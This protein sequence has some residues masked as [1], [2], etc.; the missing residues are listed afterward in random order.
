MT[1]RSYAE[2][3]TSPHRGAGR[4]RASLLGAVACAAL[5]MAAAPAMAADTTSDAAA[6]ATANTAAD[7]ADAV[8]EGSVG[9]IVVTARH[10]VESAQSAPLAV[11]VVGGD[12]IA[13]TNTNN[14]AQLV[15]FVPS[16]Q[17][18]AFN[19]RNSSINIRGLGN[20]TGVASDGTE[21]GVGFYVDQVYFNRPAQ[22]TFDL[23]DV[24]RVEVLKGPQG[25][26]FGKNTTAGAISITT[27]SPTFTPQA[28]GEVSGGS[29]GYFVAK[30][31]VSGP[32]VG[33]VLAGRLSLSTSRRDGLATNDFDG[34]KVNGYRNFSARGQLLYQ[35]NEELKVRFIGDY[36]RQ[37]ANCCYQVLAGIV[38]PP[39]GKNYRSIAQAFGYTPVVDPYERHANANNTVSAQ[40]E[41]GGVSLQADWAQPKY[42]LS[43]ITAWRFWNWWPRNDVDYSPLSVM[44][45]ADQVNHQNQFTQEFRIA[46]AGENKLDYVAGLYFYREQIKG[47]STQRYGDAASYLLFGPSVP[48][49]VANGYGLDTTS[50]A[51]TTSYAAYGQATLHLTDQWR[52]T[53]GLRYTQ[54]NKKGRFDQTVGGGAPLTGPLAPLAA[55]RAALAVP[56]SYKAKTDDSDVSGQLNL[57]YQATDDILAYGNLARGYRSGGINLSQLPAGAS[58]TIDPETV[59]SA[60]IGLKTRFLDRRVTLNVAAYYQ[61]DKDYQGTMV[62]TGTT[63]T[64]LANIPKVEVKGVEVDLRAEPNRHLSFYASAAYND[65]NYKSYPDAPCGLENILSTSCDLSGRPLAGVPLWSVSAGAEFRQP[66]TLGARE[67]EAYAAVDD[68][69]RSSIY[70]NTTDSIYSRLPSLNLVDARLGVRAADGGW[71]AYVWGR[72]IL[73]KKYFTARAPGLGNTGAIYAALG[74]PAT[75]G[76][77]LR[78][79][80]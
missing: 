22:A 14:F 77:T 70:S 29:Y 2:L 23:V 64:Y 24:E 43:S 51:D 17:F 68:S 47:Y 4:R 69:F 15:K 37:T 34:D 5:A 73:D 35:P 1:D 75:W 41:S 3:S 71:D 18:T 79:R 10:R 30:G 62:V 57:A 26:L 52:L 36:S 28:V 60:E 42:V 31:A 65:A 38:T 9:E 53:G 40:Q 6:D 8:P 13:Q 19:P 63:K 58:A 12:F 76:V 78:A 11:S 56:V 55:L 25:V 74:D 48:A 7:D 33:D 80:Y 49:V 20:A 46:S 67:V 16:V 44:T 72:N 32:L 21:P 54:D 59:D 50:S 27:A 45:K 61:R 39:N 66:L